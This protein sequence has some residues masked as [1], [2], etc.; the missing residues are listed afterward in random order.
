M[1]LDLAGDY[2]W[3]L[4]RSDWKRTMTWENEDI[5]FNNNLSKADT[6]YGKTGKLSDEWLN[7]LNARE[8]LAY[9]TYRPEHYSQI[10]SY[11][12]NNRDYIKFIYADFSIG[13][14]DAGSFSER[15]K[16]RIDQKRD[17]CAYLLTN[18]IKENLYDER[19]YNTALLVLCNTWEA[20]PFLIEAHK[21]YGFHHS[22]YMIVLR[23][24][25][26][27]NS[28][29]PYFNFQRETSKAEGNP[30]V[31]TVILNTKENQKKLIELAEGLYQLKS[32]K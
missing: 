14:V 18:Y 24:L 21:M 26:V 2:E 25:M 20:I 28:Y 19:R 9:C 16:K 10:C 13:A 6:L 11:I 29:E 32:K 5:A 31:T 7:K 30:E 3:D 23:E 27:L 12:P 4:Y 15:Q 17:S 1:I 8:L 22:Q